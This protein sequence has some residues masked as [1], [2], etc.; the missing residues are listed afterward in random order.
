MVITPSL[1]HWTKK[2]TLHINNNNTRVYRFRYKK[3]LANVW[4][5]G[6]QQLF[7][8]FNDFV[9]LKRKKCVKKC[10]YYMTTTSKYLMKFLL[11]MKTG[12]TAIFELLFRV[13]FSFKIGRDVLWTNWTSEVIWVGGSGGCYSMMGVLLGKICT[14]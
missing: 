11:A 9:E 13:I 5:Y 12:F 6:N 14:I 7:E 10:I 4:K 2:T 3:T 8:N 1:M